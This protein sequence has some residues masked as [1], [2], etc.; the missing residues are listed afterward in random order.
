MVH[1]VD[2]KIGKANGFVALQI[3]NGADIKIRWKDIMIRE[4]TTRWP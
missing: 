1:L 4:L 2:E 3:H